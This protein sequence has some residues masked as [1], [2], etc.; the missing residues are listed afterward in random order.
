MKKLKCTALLML[1]LT[2]N[3]NS[4]AI[5]SKE[6]L[7]YAQT[8]NGSYYVLGDSRWSQEKKKWISSKMA[9]HK[10]GVYKNKVGVDCAGLVL[11]AWQW[12]G[13]RAHDEKLPYNEKTMYRKLHTSEMKKASVT[14]KN[15]NGKKVTQSLPWSKTKLD[16]LAS[17]E[18]GDMMVNY[19]GGKVGHTFLVRE[20]KAGSVQTIEAR[21]ASYGVGFF[22][23]TL[24]SVQS[25]KYLAYRHPE[26]KMSSGK[27]KQ[28]QMII[29]GKVGFN[30]SY[31]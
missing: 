19:N 9:I 5:S 26:R 16:K 31:I 17:A 22:K 18:A 21:G 29:L 12:G 25:S 24:S 6:I 7:N 11:K 8:A 28:G 20:I 27:Q 15:S 4:W 3:Q 14:V 23:R 13:K 1:M 2:M 10:S 30:D